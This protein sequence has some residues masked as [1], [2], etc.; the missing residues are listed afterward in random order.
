IKDVTFP[1]EY[2]AQ[3]LGEAAH[4]RTTLRP[5]YPYMAAAAILMFLLLQA[6]LGSWRLAMLSLLGVPVAF[7]GGL[8]AAWVGG[9]LFSLGSLLG[10]VTVLGLSTRTGIMLV[11]HFQHLQRNEGEHFGKTL[12]A[13]G[14]RERFTPIVAT[15]VITL[16]LILPFVV[17]GD[18]AGLE[19]LHPAAV[20]VLGGLIVSTVFM[21]L[22]VPAIYLRF[23]AGSADPDPLRLAAKVA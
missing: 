8:L 14:V 5:L 18:I 19:I 15:T 23:G 7:A 3:V 1:F 13:R 21:L 11:G 9:G 4:R 17:R 10:F 2:H 6:A 16:L 20:V 22:V 12:V